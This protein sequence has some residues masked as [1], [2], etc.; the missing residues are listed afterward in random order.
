[1]F[2]PKRL[3]AFIRRATE[4]LPPDAAVL[5]EDISANLRTFL[6]STLS[7]MDLVTR[8][9]FDVQRAVLQRTREKLELL[10][11]RVAELEAAEGGDKG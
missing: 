10:E 3:D 5:R 2:D 7:R 6:E 1:M 9:E 11:K 4:S 8:E